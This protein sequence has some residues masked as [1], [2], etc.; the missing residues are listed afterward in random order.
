MQ[1]HLKENDC[2][3]N[4]INTQILYIV[5]NLKPY[6]NKAHVGIKIIFF[7]IFLLQTMFAKIFQTYIN[8]SQCFKNIF[9]KKILETEIV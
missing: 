2:L 1:L 6:V 3:D 9:V 7:L 4:S 8:F 5:D